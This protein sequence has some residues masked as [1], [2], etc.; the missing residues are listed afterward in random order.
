MRHYRKSENTSMLLA[1]V[2]GW[3]LL[4]SVLG[5]AVFQVGCSRQKEGQAGTDTRVA[6]AA[7]A[8]SSGSSATASFKTSNPPVPYGLALAERLR[9]EAAAR[10]ADTPK[11]EDVLAAVVKSGVPLQEQSQHLASPIG[12]RF[13]VGAKSSQ[14]VA[15][16]ACEY[17][18]ATAAAAGRDASAKAFGMV[19]H[20]DVVVNRKTTLTILQAPFDSESQAA[21]DK[22]VAAFRNL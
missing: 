17:A 7:S 10:P 18:D 6:A 21:H 13:C 3:F 1:R 4:W 11:A 15:M 5:I 22:A 12:A 14:N 19:D 20:R 9:L 16:S 8:S 2:E